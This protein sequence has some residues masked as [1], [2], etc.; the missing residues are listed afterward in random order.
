MLVFIE[1]IERPPD[2]YE[3]RNVF[4]AK[5]DVKRSVLSH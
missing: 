5:I 2:T 1:W 4:T 3:F